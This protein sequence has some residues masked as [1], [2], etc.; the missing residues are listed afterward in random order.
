MTALYQQVSDDILR[1]VQSGALKIGDKLP[2]EANFAAELGVS[3]STLRLAFAELERVGVLLR[4][5]KAGT[6]IIADQPKQHFN[7]STTGL[8]ELLS[9]GR[10]TE[11]VITAT[12]TVHTQSISHLD[13]YD[14]ETNHWLEISG[15][16]TL[17]T[18]TTPFN[19]TQVY[20][21]ARY[22][23]IEHVLRPTEMSVFKSIEEQFGVSVGRVGQ[24]AK[25][26][27]CPSDAA[28]IIGLKTGAPA[29]RIVAELNCHDGS[30]ME[31]SVATFDPERFQ[32]RTDVEIE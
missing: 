6:K 23:G 10:D 8:H 25:A 17:P 4:K 28:V 5:K 19:S 20:V 13:G 26:I 9:L 7:M 31:I 2:P 21:P 16:R 3:R 27:A 11:L 15:T 1:Q 29:L 14:S 24:T 32:L 22:A 12:R 18:E 30:L